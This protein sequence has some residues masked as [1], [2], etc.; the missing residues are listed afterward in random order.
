MPIYHKELEKCQRYFRYYGGKTSENSQMIILGSGIASS[1]SLL[2]W[3]IPIKE[4]MVSNPNIVS[5][6]D[7]VVNRGFTSSVASIGALPTATL[8]SST[9]FEGIDGLY[10]QTIASNLT[11]SAP[12]Y[13]F[14]PATA[15]VDE[16]DETIAY[17][18]FDAAP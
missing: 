11:I 4:Q 10:L 7:L 12:Y 14:L 3:C 18:I 1:S 13:V 15:S 8:A 2:E 5:S 9:F 6:V 17:I 16:G